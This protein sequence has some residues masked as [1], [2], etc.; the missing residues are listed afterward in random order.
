M[1]HVKEIR[2][3]GDKLSFDNLQT[4]CLRHHNQKTA[5]SKMKRRKNGT[6]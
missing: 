1:D 5:W 2:D 4:L 3:G 6:L